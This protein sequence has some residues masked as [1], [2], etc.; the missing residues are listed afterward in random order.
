MPLLERIHAR[1]SRLSC[2]QITDVVRPRGTTLRL[3]SAAKSLSVF[4]KKN[5]RWCGAIFLARSQRRYGISMLD[6][7]WG[8]RL[9]C[10]RN[11]GGSWTSISPN[12]PT[13]SDSASGFADT[14]ARPV[15]ADAACGARATLEGRSQGWVGSVSRRR[16]RC[17][18]WPRV[19]EISLAHQ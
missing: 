11:P 9:I 18:R 19:G 3:P 12:A 4:W 14:R 6:E 2:P 16:R 17:G 7:R 13:P 1:H 10:R 5:R 8:V 15:P